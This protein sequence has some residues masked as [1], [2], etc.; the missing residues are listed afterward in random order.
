MFAVRNIDIHFI[1]SL[2]L[3]LVNPVE[4]NDKIIEKWRLPGEKINS[5]VIFVIKQSKMIL[6]W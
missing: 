2:L 1:T 4:R 6:K 3:L 5:P